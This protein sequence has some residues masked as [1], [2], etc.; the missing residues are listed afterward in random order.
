M[1]RFRNRNPIKLDKNG[2]V[3]I[4]EKIVRHH[5]NLYLRARGIFYWHNLQGLGCFKGL[6]D[7]EGVHRGRHFY[8]EVKSPRAYVHQ[9]PE[10]KE[11]QRRVEAEGE[12]YILANNVEAVEKEL[13]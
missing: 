1:I 12:L 8:I 7:I 9:N 2:K 13:K 5:I 10:Q 4:T 3:I 11:F 6:P